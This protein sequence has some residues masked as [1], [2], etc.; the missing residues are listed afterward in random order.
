MSYCHPSLCEDVNAQF[1]RCRSTLL[2]ARA[3]YVA[4]KGELARRHKRT[5]ADTASAFEEE[6]HC[7]ARRSMEGSGRV[8]GGKTE[9][10]RRLFSALSGSSA[11][12]TRLVSAFAPGYNLPAWGIN[13]FFFLYF[14]FRSC[15]TW[16]N[17]SQ[18]CSSNRRAPL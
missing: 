13:T 11:V 8:R 7:A 3:K 5:H 18:K 16:N 12:D 17:F 9:T 14:F 1:E 15:T 6:A 2:L 10:S 4:G